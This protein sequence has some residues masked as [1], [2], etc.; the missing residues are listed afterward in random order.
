MFGH[1]ASSLSFV[2]AGAAQEQNSNPYQDRNALKKQRLR[3][4]EET[5]DE[6]EEQAIAAT[7]GQDPHEGAAK[8]K[9][10]TQIYPSSFLSLS[11]QSADSIVLPSPTTLGS[12][13]AHHLPFESLELEAQPHFLPRPEP[14]QEDDDYDRFNLVSQ[15]DASQL[16]GPAESKETA[17]ALVS[18]DALESLETLFQEIIMQRNSQASASLLPLASSLGLHA[19]IAANYAAPPAHSSTSFWQAAP[20]ASRQIN[21]FDS[22]SAN[23]T[24][25]PATDNS[26]LGFNAC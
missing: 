22:L 9:Q 11:M 7:E 17:I 23:P 14:T 18:E 25:E 20:S 4:R 2:A 10:R 13:G 1:S 21:R 5:N 26:R 3:D 24:T 19:S 8:K 12:L 16:E 6:A 15:A